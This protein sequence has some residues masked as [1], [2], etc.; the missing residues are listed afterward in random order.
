[1]TIVH[2]QPVDSSSIASVGYDQ[3]TQ[4][5]A[6]HFKANGKTYHYQEVP[7]DVYHRLMAAQSVGKFIGQH[8]RGKFS[9]QAHETA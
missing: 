3:T 4:T 6:V 5:L 2:M 9:H 7:S 1:M 8:V